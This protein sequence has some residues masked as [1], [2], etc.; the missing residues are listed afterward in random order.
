MTS[1][2]AVV[3]SV[4]LA[5]TV[6]AAVA[7][8]IPSFRVVRDDPPV[9]EDP[10]YYVDYHKRT[11]YRTR[12]VVEWGWGW[13]AGVAVGSLAGGISYRSVRARPTPTA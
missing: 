11:S 9:G 2:R 1:P 12:T 4:L 13:I 6:G 10:F 8:V 5:A 7:L 3:R